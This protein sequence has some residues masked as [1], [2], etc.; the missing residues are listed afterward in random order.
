[1]H[2]WE[3]HRSFGIKLFRSLKLIKNLLPAQCRP[4]RTPALFR[5][6]PLVGTA[7]AAT[8][9]RLPLPQYTWLP[10]PRLVTPPIRAA[11]PRAVSAQR[12]PPALPRVPVPPPSVGARSMGR[13][14][15]PHQ[16][17]VRDVDSPP[18]PPTRSGAVDT[19]AAGGT[20]RQNRGLHRAAGKFASDQR[21]K[22]RGSK[23]VSTV[24]TYLKE[25]IGGAENLNASRLFFLFETKPHH[26]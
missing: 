15:R 10:F 26:W 3:M 5:I 7:P 11:Q 14:F 4:A 1:M 23:R 17:V 6:P 18:L 22:E 19:D 13:L 2:T 9:R 20:S 24:K 8:P 12:L 25:I 16:T 21:R